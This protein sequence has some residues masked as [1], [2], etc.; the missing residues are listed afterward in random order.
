MKQHYRL[1]VGLLVAAVLVGINAFGQDNP[2]AAAA[3]PAANPRP[4]SPA[5]N[6][7]PSAPRPGKRDVVVET[8]VG[9]N[10]QT[11]REMLDA[12]A[13]LSVLDQADLAK[14]YLQKIL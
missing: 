9:S 5:P 14:G 3:P 6:E 12:A 8:I 2:P 7:T 1:Q 11:P 4:A 13:L 10:P